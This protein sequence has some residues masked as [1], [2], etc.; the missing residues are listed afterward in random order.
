MKDKQIINKINN[1]EVI[2]ASEVEEFFYEESDD[3]VP[4]GDVVGIEVNNSKSS[5]L[6]L[7]SNIYWSDKNL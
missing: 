3:A 6:V 2:C 1:W 5:E 4:E 7:F